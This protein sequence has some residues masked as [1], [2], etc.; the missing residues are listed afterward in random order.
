ML[1]GLIAWMRS[2]RLSGGQ[3][4]QQTNN[5]LVIVPP[6]APDRAAWSNVLTGCCDC[7]CFHDFDYSIGPSGALHIRGRRN[8]A[9]TATIRRERSFRFTA[10]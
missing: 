5:G 2:W 8:E 7:G 3:I 9:M 10:R 4:Q 1:L 6:D